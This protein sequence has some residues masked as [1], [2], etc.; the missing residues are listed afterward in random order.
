MTLRNIALSAVLSSL[1]VA[2]H[3]SDAILG[4]ATQFTSPNDVVERCVRIQP[5]PGGSYSKSDA[6]EEEFPAA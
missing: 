6:E 1:P 4:D 5:I 3:A 2:L